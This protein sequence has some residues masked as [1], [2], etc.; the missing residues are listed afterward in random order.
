MRRSC[1]PRPSGR[2]AIPGSGRVSSRGTWRSLTAWTTGSWLAASWMPA[3]RTG[4]LFLRRR[5]PVTGILAS[6]VQKPS[7]S[8]VLVQEIYADDYR[9]RTVTFRGQLRTTGMAGQAGLHLARTGPS[10]IPANPARPRR[11]R[12]DRPRQQRLDLA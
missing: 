11:R 9:G 5:R 4:R 3:G 12:P 2:R 7:G 8:A 6:T 1:C 10:T